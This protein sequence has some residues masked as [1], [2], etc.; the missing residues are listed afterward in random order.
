MTTRH[1]IAFATTLVIASGLE[2]AG[3]TLLAV[4]DFE[5]ARGRALCLVATGIGLGY[6]VV[7]RVQRG[8]PDR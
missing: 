2:I 4:S 7:R 6:V 8:R 5:D 3:V 1:R